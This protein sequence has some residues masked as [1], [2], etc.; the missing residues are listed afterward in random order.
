MFVGSN[1]KEMNTIGITITDSNEG[2]QVTEVKNT[3]IAF[4]IDIKPGD[5]LLN[6]GGRKVNNS[7]DVSFLLNIY[8][9]PIWIP[10]EI[11]RDNS[12][13]MKVIKFK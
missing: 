4:D 3:S 1:Y 9:N 10:I 12:N 5:I 8:D 7:F 6:I 13:L 11:K 2:V